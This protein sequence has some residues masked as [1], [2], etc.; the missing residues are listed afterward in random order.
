MGGAAKQ[1]SR[2][3]EGA[4]HTGHVHELVTCSV[5]LFSVAIGAWDGFYRFS[6]HDYRCQA[7]YLRSLYTTLSIGQKMR[8]YMRRSLVQVC[9]CLC[10]SGK[11]VNRQA[12]L[13][14]YALLPSPSLSFPRGV[15]PARHEMDMRD[16]SDALS[17]QALSLLLLLAC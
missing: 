6:C 13:T 7:D 4:G 11:R 14:C 12:R 1:A 9:L 5:P 16:L 2:C 15:C 3:E 10:T 8:D 17:N